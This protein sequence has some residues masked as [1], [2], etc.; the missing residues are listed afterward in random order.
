MAANPEHSAALFDFKMDQLIAH[1]MVSGE[2]GDALGAMDPDRWASFAATMV[3]AGV[4]PD[5]LDPTL[6]YDASFLSAR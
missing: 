1:S 6:A 5:T 4:Y 2:E 3:A